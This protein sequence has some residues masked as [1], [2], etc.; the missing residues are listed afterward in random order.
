[1][2]REAE[3]ALFRGTLAGPG[4][5]FVHGAGGVGKTA[6]LDMFAHLATDKDRLV[7]RADARDLA[8]GQDRLP[9][10]EGG[11]RPVVLID[12]Y[13][14][15]E[16]IDDWVR[17]RY[18]P[19]LPAD[20]LMVIAGRR[21]P[22]PSWRADPAWRAVT[23][24]VELGNLPTADGRSYLTGQGV[25]T[26]LHD[27]L[28][29]I[30]RGHPLTLSLLADAVR[31]GVTPRSLRDVPDVVGALVAR[32]LADAPSPRHRAALEACA[33]VPATTEDY[34]RTMLGDDAGELF[35]WLRAQPFID[36][37]PYGLC[38]HDM[39]RDLI[40]A[41]LRWRDPERYATTYRRKLVAF[42][43]R[44]RS[45]A[46]AAE[47]LE[48]V[49]RMVVLNGA[50]SPLAPLN[51]LPPTMR[52]T[53][54]TLRDSDHEP[55]AAMTLAWQG[56]EQ[57]DSVT[58]WMRR[59]PEA[60]HVFRTPD[61]EPRGYAA[62]LELTDSDLG[63]DPGADAMW[64][65]AAKHGAPR[66]GE[67]LRAWR[68]FLDRDEGQGPS[69]SMT[70]FVARQMLD[71]IL[72]SGDTAWTMV[73]VWE[74]A[75]LWAPAM[76]FLDF[77]PADGAEYEIGARSFAVFAHDWR[78]SDAREWA[79]TLHARQLGLPV[80]PA[81]DAPV[82]SE[83]EFA[84]A[85]R[86][87]LRFPDLLRDNPL[88][89]S[90]MIRRH[91][92]PGRSPADTLREMIEAGA[93]TLPADQAEL[94]ARTFLRPTTTQARVAATLHLSFNTY[95][96]HRDRAVAQLT[97]W[98]WE[99]E[100]GRCPDHHVDPHCR[101]QPTEETTVDTPRLLIRPFT[102]D[103]L[104]DFLSYQA[105]PEVRRYLPGDPMT[106]DKAADY[107][108]AQ[109]ALDDHALDAWH[110]FAV[111]HKADDRM[112]GDIGVWLPADPANA[113]DVGFQFHP[114]YHGKGYATEAVEAFLHHVFQTWSPPRITA[115]CNPANTASR[116]LMTRLGMRLHT[117]NPQFIQYD[118]S[119]SHGTARPREYS[120]ARPESGVPVPSR[121]A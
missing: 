71:I 15:L 19:S 42:Q 107:L 45:V 50:R 3:L 14:L 83:P 1:M 118:L 85:V 104:T 94:L 69:P 53:V 109:S 48:L 93:A 101:T 68:F 111:H 88:L 24:V 13:E 37:G 90:A 61:G 16:P 58:H 10:P 108:R 97:A 8:L 121:S 77:E 4:V 89:G 80:R 40:D 52:S 59:Q 17:E 31:R 66:G 57:T 72:L 49:V 21:A 86:S 110:G 74:D 7:V 46:D 44:I 102:A 18:L 76:E 79:E 28:L 34:L 114:A 55:I 119:R 22:R 65:Y 106:P 20:C 2:G 81:P 62:C 11:N 78:R 29:T 30:S 6:L 84:D 39:V 54:G 32:L 47:Q 75:R 100:T 95:R 9:V 27:S 33:Q 26:S 67:R 23:R 5:L 113:P 120:A 38:P 99:Q 35:T 112:I 56:A 60:F 117:E 41:D 115:T 82:L 96:R 51:A 43:D 25:A 36:E 103:D 73:G 92:R 105:D 63:V 12:T 116:A 87:A 64:R 70:L 98:L 91:A